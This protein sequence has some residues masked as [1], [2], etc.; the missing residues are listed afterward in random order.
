MNLP[1]RTYHTLQPNLSGERLRWKLEGVKI[2]TYIKSDSRN[3]MQWLRNP[4]RRRTS[5][6]EVA[7]LCDRDI[8]IWDLEIH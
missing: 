6:V 8:N 1:L 2:G 7:D 4:R 5:Q 3:V